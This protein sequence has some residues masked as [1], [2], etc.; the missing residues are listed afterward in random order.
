MRGDEEG[1]VY[2]YWQ[3]KNA[4]DRIKYHDTDTDGTKETAAGWWLR[5]SFKSN[6]FFLMVNL[7]GNYDYHGSGSAPYTTSFAFCV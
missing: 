5:S 2:E 4:T 7:R 6:I 3:G 1:T